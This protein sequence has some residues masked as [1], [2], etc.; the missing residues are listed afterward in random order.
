MFLE[1]HH[2][3]IVEDM[4]CM[5]RGV[6]G[7]RIASAP[8]SAS[9]QME[10]F[11]TVV[12]GESVREREREKGFAMK[13][14]SSPC[15]SCPPESDGQLAADVSVVP[16][17]RGSGAHC[18]GKRSSVD[19]KDLYGL[20]RD[21]WG[22]HS[23]QNYHSARYDRRRWYVRAVRAYVQGRVCVNI[24]VCMY[25]G[26]PGKVNCNDPVYVEQLVKLLAQGKTQLR[27]AFGEDIDMGRALW[28]RAC[29]CFYECD[30]CL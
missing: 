4:P 13:C 25:A 29:R 3:V 15:I 11:A 17:R 12:N 30:P 28:V 8:E 14:I 26:T 18:R 1:E 10:S 22:R 23:S 5:L 2:A 21:G 27:F 7:E 6:F 20:Y 16:R 19:G 9:G 24:G